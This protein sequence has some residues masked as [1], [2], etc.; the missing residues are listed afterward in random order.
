MTADPTRIR[1]V[2]AAIAASTT[3]AADN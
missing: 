3:S 1:A 2:R